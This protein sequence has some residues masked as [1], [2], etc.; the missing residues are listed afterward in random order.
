MPWRH[1]CRSPSPYH[2]GRKRPS[3]LTSAKPCCGCLEE[4]GD[5]PGIVYALARHGSAARLLRSSDAAD[6]LEVRADIARLRRADVQMRLLAEPYLHAKAT[7]TPTQ[8]WVGSQNWSD[9]AMQTNREVGLAVTNSLIH[10]QALQ[11][12][13]Q[14]WTTAD[15]WQSYGG[16]TYAL[17]F[18]RTH[19]GV[20]K[21]FLPSSLQDR[22]WQGRI[23]ASG[24]RTM[25][26]ICDVA[27]I[28]PL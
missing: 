5:A 22:S 16:G 21:R 17:V 1:R 2:P 27:P 11:W 13:N 24:T 8:T 18:E 3:T 23:V 20:Q 19:V 25:A 9:P 7:M 26:T 10:R 4:L 12:F 28:N 6:S 14:L 15:L